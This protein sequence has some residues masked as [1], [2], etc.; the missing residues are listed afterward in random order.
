MKISILAAT[1]T[2]TIAATIAVP[3]AAH[4]DPTPP[5]SDGQVQVSSGGLESAAVGSQLGALRR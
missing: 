1:T 2:A 3:A 5:C 4:G